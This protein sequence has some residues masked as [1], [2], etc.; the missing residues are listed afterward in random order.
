[1]PGGAVHRE[2]RSH[3]A[4]NGTSELFMPVPDKSCQA[5]ILAWQR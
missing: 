5:G 3:D 4:K 1:M 2:L